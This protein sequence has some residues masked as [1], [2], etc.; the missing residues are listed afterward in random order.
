MVIDHHSLWE[1]LSVGVTTGIASYKKSLGT[2]A[3]N[4]ATEVEAI[5][6]QLQTGLSGGIKTLIFGRED[7]AALKRSAKGL[8]EIGKEFGGIDLS[9][10]GEN[11]A[12]TQA[13]TQG[14]QNAFERAGEGLSGD[15]GRRTKAVRDQFLG[16]SS[17]DATPE[18]VAAAMSA[19]HDLID[20]IE[21]QTGILGRMRSFGSQM[22][23][24]MVE[25]FQTSI[26]DLLA[27]EVMKGLISL[28]ESAV[29]GLLG[30]EA[31][32][33]GS[34][35][36]GGIGSGV[37]ESSNP[38]DTLRGKFLDALLGVG[39]LVST[40]ANAIADGLRTT[41]DLAAN[42]FQRLRGWLWDALLSAGD[43]VGDGANAIADGLRTTFDLAANAF[44]MLSR[45]MV[46]ALSAAGD[47]VGDGAKVLASGI[48][49]FF[50]LEPNAF[51]QLRGWLWDAL[52]SAGDLIQGGAKAIAAELRD[53]F[54]L[55]PNAFQRLSGWMVDALEDAGTLVDTGGKGLA[56][57][58]HR[59]FS[60][61]WEGSSFGFIRRKIADSVGGFDFTTIGGSAVGIGGKLLSAFGTFW[62]GSSFEFIATKL[63]TWTEGKALSD[64]P[65][66][67]LA[68]KILD[69]LSSAWSGSSFDF[70]SNKLGQVFDML[71]TGAGSLGSKLGM[72]IKNGMAMWAVGKSFEEL[73]GI[74][75]PDPIINGLAFAEGVLGLFGTNIAEAVV[76]P[77]ASAISNAFTSAGAL[78][79]GG[80]WSSAIGL[81]L[82]NPLVLAFT[83]AAAALIFPN[84]F[85]SMV[86][87]LENA[88]GIGSAEPRPGVTET[89]TSVPGA[90]AGFDVAPGSDVADR[91]GG[92]GTFNVAGQRTGESSQV[93]FATRL[94]QWLE[95]VFE[96]RQISRSV[97]RAFGL[98]S[99]LGTV[100]AISSGWP[101]SLG[102]EFETAFANLAKGV[103]MEE[104]EATIQR[105]GFGVVAKS[106][107]HRVPG[108]PNTPVPAILHGGEMVLPARQAEQ[109][110]SG[111]ANAGGITINF[112]LSS[113]SDREMVQ[114]LR[115]QLPMIEEA[116]TQGIRKGARFGSQEFDAR[117]IRSTLQS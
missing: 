78:L 100:T 101:G 114:M 74:D 54:G 16:L 99:E 10:F 92:S 89:L 110:R 57:E 8:K 6:G 18:S 14:L 30:Q 33:T 4:V 115:S 106:G 19:L 40:G 94:G 38:F 108:S 20:R 65:G 44:Q 35:I 85:V 53:L 107:L 79:P 49:G 83:A 97:A 26:S 36:S 116:V 32:K 21:D 86:T 68:G 31:K 90:G 7:E 5:L 71:P 84:E 67:G 80:S 72:G 109:V 55:E 51:Q 103:R 23:D 13:T 2:F 48:R 66:A 15:L 87:R 82:G 46:D 17:P 69:G 45:W 1:R 25:G 81:L 76:A 42:A 27:A 11:A 59:V 63:K 37:H 70:V 98:E 39:D 47:L 93:P 105:S 34:A 28:G 24:V 60:A 22:R 77:L 43:L 91:V 112:N 73:T 61:F 117:M 41:F 88:L 75:I 29:S 58:I 50:E 64:L 96:N 12:L 62:E 113:A 104:A 102:S 3:A 56:T 111:G 95:Q 52:L 9:T